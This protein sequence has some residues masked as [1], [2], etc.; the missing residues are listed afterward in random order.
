V[1][2]PDIGLPPGEGHGTDCSA[3]RIHGLPLTYD[4]CR[5]RFRRAATEA[6]LAVKALPIQATG[7]EG[8]ALTVDVVSLGAKHPDRC[9]VVLS[10]VHGVEGF[11]TSAMQVELLSRLAIADPTWPAG[12]ALLLVH[13]V[14]PWGMAWWRRQNESNVDLNRN[15]R[16]DDV[17]PLHNDAYDEMHAHACPD[18]DELPAIDSML[19]EAQR[20]VHDRGVA[21]VRDGITRGQY[22]HADGLHFGGDRT[23]ESTRLIEQ[24]VP[25]RLA[26]VE[27]VLTVDLHTGHGPYGE[28]TAL[29]DRPP[30]SAQDAMLRAIFDRVESTSE[31][32]AA[33]TGLKSGQIANG[34]AE[35]LPGATCFATSL[36][37]GTVDDLT[38]LGATYQEQWVYR[39]GDRTVP[40][41]A[42]AVWTYR[43]CFTPDD[44]EWEALAL[45]RGRQA[46]D[47]AVATLFDWS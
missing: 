10:G 19:A 12:A 1:T 5:A 20:W 3:V 34:L 45:E 29:S 24:V 9:L 47:R 4:E 39:R 38:Q 8:Q 14:N 43:C 25:A 13:A 17:T 31:N 33:T 15:W 35:V 2:F 23:E 37:V 6:G 28:L 11:A 41:H 16:R 7:P 22:R 26:G 42:A 46:L 30:G 27:R 44:P 36:E 18:T 40:E 32:P 21:W